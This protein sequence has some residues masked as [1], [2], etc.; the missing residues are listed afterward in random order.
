MWLK[1]DIES[2]CS[3]EWYTG[4]QSSIMNEMFCVIHDS[5]VKLNLEL[6]YVPTIMAAKPAHVFCFDDLCV[7]YYLPCI[8]VT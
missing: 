3:F 5:V 1:K 4:V 7:M 8:V 6:L 2:L